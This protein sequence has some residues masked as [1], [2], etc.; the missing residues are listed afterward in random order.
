V[1]AP[2][3]TL[4]LF[5]R[6]GSIVPLG[7]AIESTKD[8]QAIASVR[9]YSGANA[10]FTLFSDDGDTYSYEKGINSITKLSW[11]EATHQFKHDG[12]AAWSGPDKSIVEVIGR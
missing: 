12:A 2:I 1:K 8:K 11:N 3:D 4:P 5:V 6:A 9:V 10:S 7:S